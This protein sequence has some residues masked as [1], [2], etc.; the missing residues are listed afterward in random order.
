MPVPVLAIVGDG[1]IVFANAAFADMLG[2]TPAAVMSLEF[3]QIFHAL[4]VDA[5][6]VS[7]VHGSANQIVALM[8]ADGSVVKA[9]M[10]KSALLRE[11]DPLA[12]ATF[13]DLTEQLWARG[14]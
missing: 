1:S 10:S 2:Y 4:P 6:P 11:H 8:H 13:D 12:L 5:S 9:R 14:H 3:A 7:V